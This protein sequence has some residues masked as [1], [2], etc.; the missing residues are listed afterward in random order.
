MPKRTLE[1]DCTQMKKPRPVGIDGASQLNKDREIVHNTR[2][3]EIV[4][5]VDKNGKPFRESFFRSEGKS[6]VIKHVGMAFPNGGHASVALDDQG[7]VKAC[8]PVGQWLDVFVSTYLNDT[9]LQFHGDTKLLYRNSPE[10]VPRV[11]GQACDVSCTFEDRGHKGLDFRKIENMVVLFKL[12]DAP[13]AVTEL[14]KHQLRDDK[15]YALPLAIKGWGLP[16]RPVSAYFQN[17]N[18]EEL[19]AGALHFGAYS[20]QTLHLLGRCAHWYQVQVSAMLGGCAWE[21]LKVLRE[22]A[23]SHDFDAKN[24]RYVKRDELLFNVA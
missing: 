3:F 15:R 16:R 21:S 13:P 1:P 17:V 10:E 9:P 8:V 7:N 6:C 12:K 4:E 14:L 18:G 11:W 5:L 20:P 2:Q 19:P 23:L 24:E 22:F